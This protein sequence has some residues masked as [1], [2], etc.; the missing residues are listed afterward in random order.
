MVLMLPDG[1]IISDGVVIWIGTVPTG[2]GETFPAMP[3][4]VA[5]TPT[6]KRKQRNIRNL[7]ES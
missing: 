4:L 7:H 1:V 5:I 3:A 2:H 6:M